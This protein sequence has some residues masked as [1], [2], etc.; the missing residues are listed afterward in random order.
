VT[1]QEITHQIH[2]PILEGHQISSKLIAEQ[3]GI[4][5][6][7]DASIIDEDLDMQLSTKWVLKRLNVNQK[8]QPC[9]SSEQI[10]DYFC[11]AQSKRSCHDW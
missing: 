7:G 5:G 8:C 11:L 4:S 2:E 1:T 9:Q 3:L 10:L 6:E